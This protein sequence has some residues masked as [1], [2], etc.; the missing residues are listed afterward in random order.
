VGTY[1]SEAPALYAATSKIFTLMDARVSRGIQRELYAVAWTMIQGT[2]VV[3]GGVLDP[4][5]AVAMATRMRD[6]I[7]AKF[8]KE[9]ANPGDPNLVVV[10]P[11]VTVSGPNVSLSVSVNDRLFD[12]VNGIA[13]TLYNIRS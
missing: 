6:A 5:L 13:I 1:I 4:D 3:N 9:I 12:Y 11:A 8:S 7:L 10:N 2:A